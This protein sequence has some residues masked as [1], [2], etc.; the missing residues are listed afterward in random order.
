MQS[1]ISDVSTSTPRATPLIA[2]KN[3]DSTQVELQ[4]QI[5]KLNNKISKGNQ[6]NIIARISQINEDI[7]ILQA[8][9]DKEREAMKTLGLSPKTWKWGGAGATTFAVLADVGS[10]ASN[11]PL[12]ALVENTTVT[13]IVTTSVTAGVGLIAAAVLGIFTYGQYK[14]DKRMDDFDQKVRQNEL[15]SIFLNSYQT[16]MDHNPDANIAHEHLGDQVAEL[17]QCVE[18]LKNISNSTVPQQA[19]DHW[20]SAMIEKLPDENDLKKKL[21]E[22]QEL[23]IEIEEKKTNPQELFFHDASSE[24]HDFLKT[25]RADQAA[26]IAVNTMPDPL[27]EKYDANMKAFREEFGMDI[28]ELHVNGYKLKSDAKI[29]KIKNEPKKENKGSVVIDMI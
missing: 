12:T 28:Q 16:F 2:K 20:L 5:D 15:M 8:E 29:K 1:A 21:I 26:D 11:I 4:R 14:V 22:Q 7:A 18:N 23:A 27:R 6:E 17:K 10:L 3:V 13:I 24:Q 9:N 19:K 25:T